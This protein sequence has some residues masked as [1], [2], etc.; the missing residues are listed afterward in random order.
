MRHPMRIKLTR[1]GLLVYL[2]NHY[3]T[4]GAIVHGKLVHD[5]F[6]KKSA[7]P[8]IVFSLFS[9]FMIIVSFFFNIHLCTLTSLLILVVIIDRIFWLLYSDLLQ[10][11]GILG[12][13]N[14]M[15]LFNPQGYAFYP[16][17]WAG[18]DTRSIFNWSVTG[19]NLEFSF[20]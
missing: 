1:E 17:P 6:H 15:F 5:I 13:L 14:Q 7:I 11:A 4:W 9:I 18:C 2:A 16:T 10:M 8:L 20:S 3:T 19:L 12:I